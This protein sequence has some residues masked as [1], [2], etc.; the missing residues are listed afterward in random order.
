MEGEDQSSGSHQDDEGLP[1]GSSIDPRSDKYE[2]LKK[3]IESKKVEI[4]QEP[5]Q[6]YSPFLLPE[7][8]QSGPAHGKS[9]VFLAGWALTICLMGPVMSQVPDNIKTGLLAIGGSIATSIFK[10]FEK[11]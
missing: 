7:F 4:E 5:I 1:L 11:Y 10:G 8:T 2:L 6:K 3:A 9:R